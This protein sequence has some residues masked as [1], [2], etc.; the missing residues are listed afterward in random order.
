MLLDAW[1][2]ARMTVYHAR[3]LSLEPGSPDGWYR[4]VRDQ[5]RRALVRGEPV[6]EKSGNSSFISADLEGC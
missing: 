5:G 1:Q 4:R 3:H 6:V 2:R